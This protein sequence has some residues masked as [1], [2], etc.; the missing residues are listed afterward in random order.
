VLADRVNAVGAAWED[1]HRPLATWLGLCSPSPGNSA[2]PWPLAGPRYLLASDDL[3]WTEH[4][5]VAA[6]EA[7]DCPVEAL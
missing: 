4:E 1:V 6:M 3:A 7:M 5:I 2:N